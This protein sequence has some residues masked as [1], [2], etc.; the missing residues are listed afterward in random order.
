MVKRAGFTLIE[1]LVVMAVMVLLLGVSIPFFAGF[2]R[3][4][5]LK[6][7]A[8]GITAVLNSARN[9]AI[10]KR[11]N[12]SVLF[13]NSGRPHSYAIIDPQGAIYGKNY[14]LPSGIEF[15]RQSQP[16][17][18]TTFTANKVVF[19]STGGLSGSSGSVWIADKKGNFRR[20]SV[21]RSIGKVKIDQQP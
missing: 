21:S 8:K 1:L 12:Y 11:R 19:S 5:K 9:L 18:P 20:I 15:Y 17:Q 16:D 2:S 14:S 13:N 3:G 4:A 7:A 10:T 6:T